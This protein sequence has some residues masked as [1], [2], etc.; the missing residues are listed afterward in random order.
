VLS[1]ISPT[2][3]TIYSYKIII[4]TLLYSTAAEMIKA[5]KDAEKEH[6]KVRPERTAR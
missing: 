2:I 3:T 1:I 5:A 4:A 6:G